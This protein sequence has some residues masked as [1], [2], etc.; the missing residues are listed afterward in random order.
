MSFRLLIESIV[1]KSN[2]TVVGLDPTLDM[3]PT[4]IKDECIK[5]YGKTLEAAAEAVLLFNIALIDALYDIV[6]AVKPQ[7]AYYEM[8]GWQGVKALKETIDYAK[9]KRLYVITDGKRNDIGNTMQA[10]AK[11]HLGQTNVFGDNV[12]SFG[13][14]ALTVNAYLGTDGVAPLL[15]ICNEADKGIFILCKTSNKSSGELQ[16]KFID[17]QPVYSLMGSMCQKWGESTE[18]TYGYSAVGAVVGATYPEQLEILR[19]EMKNTFFLVPG[20]GAQGGKAKDV[21]LAFDSNGLGAIVNSSRGIMCAYKNNN[22][23]EKDFA[24]AAR[25]E[26]LRMRDELLSFISKPSLN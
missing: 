23:D 11:A 10:Y 26:A 22:F 3:V 5:K 4:F 25:Q 17:D 24:L 1:E 19:K 2:P 7:C 18:H 13:A 15:E 20:Y 9:A 16:D 12:E 6:P 14:D 21:A 8:L